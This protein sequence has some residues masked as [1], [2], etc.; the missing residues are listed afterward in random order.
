M[1]T[2]KQKKHIARVSLPTHV[3]MLE[4]SVATA[5]GVSLATRL[6]LLSLAKA[7]KELASSESKPTEK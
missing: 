1:Q 2:T 3:L 5:V 6:R 7:K 4:K